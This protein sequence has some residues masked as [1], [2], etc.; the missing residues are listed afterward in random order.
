MANQGAKLTGPSGLHYDELHKPVDT[1][2]DAQQVGPVVTV[3][4]YEDGKI[5][6]ITLNRPH[7][8]NSLGGGLIG[9][10]YDAFAEFRDDRQARVAILTGRGAR[11]FCAGADLI[12]TSE[13]RKAA[14]AG[15][16]VPDAG[17]EQLPVP[18]SESMDLWKP[19]IAA[20]NGFAIAGGFMM[21]MQCDIRIAA[22]HARIGIAET[23]WNMG[24]G[25][26]MAPI[27]RQIGLGIALELTL[28]GDTQ[29][30]AQ[31]AYEVGWVNK[32]VTAEELMET[33][34][35]YAQRAIDMAP[36]AVRNI[37]Q[38]LYRGFYMT[39]EV[40]TAFGNAIEQNLR[41]M[42]DSIEGPT[43]FAEKRRPNFIDG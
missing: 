6:I 27:T 20:I 21:A 32:V 4:K 35:S 38:T 10:T 15:Q 16:A 2:R 5:Y 17:E 33:A 40:A 26:W 39:P 19:T 14:A 8:M 13:R 28:W 37:K 36:R 12:E 41:G 18:L 34:M 11:A 9:A 23:R 7:R 1:G 25:R 22:E 29:F 3:D 43:A 42:Q 24:G 30:T 31:R